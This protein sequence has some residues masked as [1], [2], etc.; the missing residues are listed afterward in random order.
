MDEFAFD[1]KWCGK[2]HFSPTNPRNSLVWWEHLACHPH[3]KVTFVATIAH[4]TPSSL[5]GHGPLYWDNS[6]GDRA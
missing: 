2:I 6:M 5:L 3:G 4:P 1:L